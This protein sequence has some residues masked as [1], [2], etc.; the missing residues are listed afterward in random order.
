M[1]VFIYTACKKSGFLLFQQNLVLNLLVLP[2]SGNPHIV[3]ILAGIGHKDFLLH[4]SIWRRMPSRCTRR[5]AR[6][7]WSVKHPFKTSKIFLTRSLIT[8][9]ADTGVNLQGLFSVPEM[10]TEHITNYT[11]YSA[12]DCFASRFEAF[13]YLALRSQNFAWMI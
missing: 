12:V 8:D 3:P 6:Y 1:K 2:K 7:F 13:F 11:W 9:D 10:T 5:M 4:H